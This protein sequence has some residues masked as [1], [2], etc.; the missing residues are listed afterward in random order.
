MNFIMKKK[1][2]IEFMT[3]FSN[4]YLFSFSSTNRIIS[5]LHGNL[6]AS[7]RYCDYERDRGYFGKIVYAYT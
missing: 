1:I 3:C 5:H 4:Y 2:L 6:I 7:Y